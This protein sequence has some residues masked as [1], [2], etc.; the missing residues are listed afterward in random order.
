MKGLNFKIFLI[1]ILHIF[2]I[3]KV[4]AWSINS[5]Y[6]SFENLFATNNKWNTNNSQNQKT[7]ACKYGEVSPDCYG[8]TKNKISR[9]IKILFFIN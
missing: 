4:S 1:S 5:F 2:I 3:N 9:E 8:K 7:R 6:S